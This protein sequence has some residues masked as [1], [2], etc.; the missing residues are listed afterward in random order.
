MGKPRIEGKWVEILGIRLL[1]VTYQSCVAHFGL[2]E[3]GEGKWLTLYDIKSTCPGQGHATDLLSVMQ[4][5]SARTGRRF[6]GSIALNNRMRSIY[7][8]LG[9][10][11]YDN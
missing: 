9:I 8:R 6:G 7:R 1:E 3:D 10:H 4:S 5:A 2:G 11:E